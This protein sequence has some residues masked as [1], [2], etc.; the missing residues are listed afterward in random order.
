MWYRLTACKGK[1]CDYK[2]IQRLEQENA[3]L[4]EE[5]NDFISDISSCGFKYDNRPPVDL[6]E[7][8]GGIED[9]CNKFN[10]YKSCLQEIKEIAEY[11]ALDSYYCN[12]KEEVN[13]LLQKISE[14]SE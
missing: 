2:T 3:R 13:K 1:E 11:M 14:V 9:L 4:K 5:I 7:L 10:N 6:D 12:Y 8:R